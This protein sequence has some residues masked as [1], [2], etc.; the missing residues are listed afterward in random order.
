[1]V[2]SVLKSNQNDLCIYTIFWTLILKKYNSII[3]V[4]NVIVIICRTAINTSES[5]MLRICKNGGVMARFLSALKNQST[6]SSPTAALTIASTSSNLCEAVNLFQLES[7]AS[8]SNTPTVSFF[9]M[10]F[11]DYFLFIRNLAF[12]RFKEIYGKKQDTS[13]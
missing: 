8:T 2:S 6:Q 1:M 13:G 9:I 10:T 4:F 3:I 12:K 11:L 7:T 5:V